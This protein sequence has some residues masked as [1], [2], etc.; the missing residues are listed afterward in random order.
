MPIYGNSVGGQNSVGYADNAD[1]VDNKHADEFASA[2]ELEELKDKVGDE[3]VSSQIST[4]MEGI[5]AASHYAATLLASDWFSPTMSGA[6]YLN[7]VTVS[8]IKPTDNPIV[9]IDMSAATADN[10]EDLLDQWSL[11]G[12]IETDTDMIAAYCYSDV[13]TVDIS[14]NIV[15]IK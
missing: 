3:S 9:D 6:P 11:I 5:S 7:L 4:A 12:R 8:G 1:T 15:A 2:S 14:I 13:P 10:A